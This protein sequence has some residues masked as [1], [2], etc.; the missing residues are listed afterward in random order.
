MSDDLL[1]VDVVEETATVTLTNPNVRNALTLEMA[2][3]LREAV[4]GLDEELR[5]LVVQGSG[6]VFCAGGDVKAMVEAVND[7]TPPAERVERVALPINRAVQA[8]AECSLPTVA[9][10]DGP[11]FGAGGALAI[12]CDLTLASDRASI[13]FGF[14]Q[15]GLS[16]DSATS[17]LLPRVVGEKTAKELVFTGEMVDADRARELG[18]FSRVFPAEAFEQRAR[19]LVERVADGPTVALRSSKRLLEADHDSPA[20]AVEAE[21]AALERTLGTADHAEGV[22]AFVEGR[23]ADFAGE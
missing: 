5:C 19:E 16:V 2:R 4:E 9:K 17:H 21:A 15:V 22:A 8:V 10:V 20:A 23:D 18:L 6:G 13:G 11:A 7:G 1:R 14:R 3:R 12:A